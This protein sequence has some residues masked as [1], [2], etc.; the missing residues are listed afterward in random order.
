M[1]W[2]CTVPAHAHGCDAAQRR[3]AQWTPVEHGHGS[4]VPR[5]G[6]QR[7]P[8]HRTRYTILAG[9][10]Q[11][12]ALCRRILRVMRTR[13]QPRRP[14]LPL[15]RL[16]ASRRLGVQ[17]A[18]GLPECATPPEEVYELAKRRGMD[19]VTIT[20][21]DTIDGVPGDR[22]PARLLRLRG[23][24]RPLPRRA[25]G[26]A[27]PLLR[28]HART[29]TSGCRRTPATSRPAPR[30]CTS[31]EIACALA[32]PFYT[33]AAPLTPR[34]RRRLARAVPVWE[35]RNGSRARGAQHA[36]RDLHRDARRHR[37]RRLRRP[38]RR[39]H[40]PHLHRGAARAATP[41]RVPR[42]HARRRRRRARGEQGSAAKWAHAAMALAM[43]ALGRRRRRRA[44]RPTRGRCCRWSSG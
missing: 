37:H 13:R 6:A 44:P 7:P 12:A 35:V 20:D 23:A 15:D 11:T 16:A 8:L 17:R 22:R 4:D 39:R 40:R 31:N 42:A 32:H 9:H 18:L 25:A 2:S 28:D 34:H 29:T 30:T 26:G 27:R 3:E 21:H 24:D 19:F 1:N 14:A 5:R 41:A 10:S 38:R 43:R 36:R 33:V